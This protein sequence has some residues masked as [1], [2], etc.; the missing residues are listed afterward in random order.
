MND[1]EI[2][3]AM[4]GIVA[5]GA[6]LGAFASIISYKISCWYYMRKWCDAWKEVARRNAER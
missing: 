6:V 1:P 4:I 3:W 5:I 2:F